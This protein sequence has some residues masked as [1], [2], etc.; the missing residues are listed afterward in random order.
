[1]FN[2]FKKRKRIDEQPQVQNS[3]IKEPAGNKCPYCNA[4][5]D[6]EPKGKFKCPSCGNEIHIQKTGEKIRLLT[7]D[8]RI[9]LNAERAERAAENRYFNFFDG[10]SVSREY[11][12]Q[13]RSEFYKLMG[14]KANYPDLTL[15]V[16][17]VL[18]QKFMRSGRYKDNAQIYFRMAR[19]Y[20][21]EGRDFIMLLEEGYRMELYVIEKQM[22]E[23]GF[24]Y[25]IVIITRG[26]D[27]CP[28]CG[29]YKGKR[30][31]LK[32]ALEEMP[33]PVKGC[34]NELGC[35]CFYGTNTLR[36]Q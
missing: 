25:E 7:K 2:F 33:L 36:T 14:N 22:K 5:V 27:A 9:K 21:Q 13:K 23:L 30:F 16:A 1:M 35:R 12:E 17:H 8:Q 4:V 29:E 31:T 26:L 19:M 34:T 3:I 20:Q 18:L 10:I 24:P 28:V 11:L 15:S 6:K 32:Q